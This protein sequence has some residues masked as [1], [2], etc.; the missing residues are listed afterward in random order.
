MAK[1]PINTLKIGKLYGVKND[2]DAM[3][4]IEGFD[5]SKL[6][7]NFYRVNTDKYEEDP[8]LTAA[9]GRKHLRPVQ[10]KVAEDELVWPMAAISG[11]MSNE[12][13][14]STGRKPSQ[15]E[16]ASMFNQ[17]FINTAKLKGNFLDVDN[18]LDNPDDL[19]RE[20][21]GTATDFSPN[22]K[23]YSQRANIV[24]RVNLQ[25]QEFGESIPEDVKGR[26]F[27]RGIELEEAEALAGQYIKSAREKS[28]AKE[29]ELLPGRQE[30]DIQ[31]LESAMQNSAGSFFNEQI[32]PGIS[33][34][35]G[36]RR[37]LNS[38]DLAS[39]LAEAG[40]GLQRNIQ[41]TIAPLRYDVKTG[42]RARGYENLLRGALESGQSLS[43]ALNLSRGM[44]EADRARGFAASQEALGMASEDERWR[45]S[46]ALQLALSSGRSNP[47]P[48]D[49]FLQFAVPG[50]TQFGSE[51]IKGKYGKD[52]SNKNRGKAT[53]FGDRGT[54]YEKGGSENA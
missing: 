5:L 20:F 22:L 35:L 24:D 52:G 15:T 21:I 50:I 3:R 12:F 28:I 4:M 49:Y 18:L 16:L 30:K 37:L 13:E 44:Y 23:V 33:R 31:E 40:G 54:Y 1:P 7:D 14:K 2:V 9:S 19:I 11:Y 39:S 45:Q 17:T 34:D 42:S 8:R 26:I 29:N 48:L 51:F 10:E 38:G 41:S 47:S 43:S 36:A 6:A 32:I 27:A 25:L 53:S 46:M